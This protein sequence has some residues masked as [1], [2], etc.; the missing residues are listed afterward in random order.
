MRLAALK[1]RKALTAAATDTLEA[2]RKKQTEVQDG[3]R[4]FRRLQDDTRDQ[5]QR[6]LEE[7]EEKEVCD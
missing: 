6:R 7:L 5:L 2:L 3:E 1:A 4:E